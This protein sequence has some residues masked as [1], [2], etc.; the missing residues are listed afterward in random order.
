[1]TSL[2]KFLEIALMETGDTTGGIEHPSAYA[3]MAPDDAEGHYF[4]GV[5]LKAKGDREQ[6]R[7][8]FAEAAR[9]Q[10]NNSQY[11]AVAEN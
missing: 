9:L 6:A 8:Q 2:T 11:K 4:L 3:R 5:A 1:M 10:P 7:T